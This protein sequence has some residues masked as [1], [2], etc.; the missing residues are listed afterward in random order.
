MNYCNLLEQLLNG[1]KEQRNSVTPGPQPPLLYLLPLL[2]CYRNNFLNLFL[3][4]L[5]ANRKN[6]TAITQAIAHNQAQGSG[7]YSP[8][9]PTFHG[10][11]VEH[12]DQFLTAFNRHANYTSSR[13]RVTNDFALLLLVM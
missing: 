13:C 7:D 12:V 9:P 3:V 8:K 10:D 6:T 1:T 5:L 2:P 11:R 4:L